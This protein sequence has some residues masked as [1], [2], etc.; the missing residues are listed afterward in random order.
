MT[1]PDAYRPT[2]P[3]LGKPSTYKHTLFILNCLYENKS[4]FNFQASG[5]TSQK[6][7]A[8]MIYVRGRIYT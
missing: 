5:N 8:E 6:A 3:H 1:G 2:D 4:Y 7:C